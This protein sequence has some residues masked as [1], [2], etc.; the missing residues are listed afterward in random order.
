MERGFHFVGYPLF[1]FLDF[2]ALFWNSPEMA[3]SIRE[4]EIELEAN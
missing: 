2:L 4:D 3:I 1:P